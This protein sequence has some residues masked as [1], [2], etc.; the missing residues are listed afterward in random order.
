MASRIP[1]F[2]GRL[3]ASA[4]RL[5]SRTS[6]LVVQCSRPYS[7]QPPKSRRNDEVKFWPF[8]VVALVGT[9][10]YVALVNRRSG[11]IHNPDPH[12]KFT[13]SF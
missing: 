13:S 6:P 3:A 8:L 1:F 10:G 2:T 7:S 9:G 11:R 12:K 5:T 4:S